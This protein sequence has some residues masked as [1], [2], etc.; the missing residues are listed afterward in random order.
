MIIAIV[1]Q[2]TG[3]AWARDAEGNL[4]PLAEG[5]RLTEGEVVITETG[6]RVNLVQPDGTRLAQLGGEVEV[7]ISEAINEQG[8]ADDEVIEDAEVARVLALLEEGE[9]DL[10]EALEAPAAGSAG[11]AG[12]EGGHD[13]VRLLRIVE[14]VSPLSFEYGYQREVYDVQEQDGG[15]AADED[16]SVTLTGLDG[17]AGAAGSA[18]IGFS[19]A[20]QTVSEAGLPGGSGSGTAATSASGSFGVSAPDGLS[21]I[22]VGG[23]GPISLDRLNGLSGN[24]LTIETPLGSLTLTS[25]SG[26]DTGGSVAYTYDLTDNVDN[27]SVDGATDD[28]V[29]DSIEISAV[30]SDG[31]TTSGTLDIAILDDAPEAVDDAT[32]TGEDTAVTYN[33][34][35]NTDGTSD[36]QG[37]DGASVTA[38]SLRNLSQGSVSFD[39]NTGEVTFTPADGFEGDAV[40]DYTIT[41]AD[42]DTSDAVFTVTVAADSTPTVSVPDESPDAEGGQ[43]SVSEAGLPGGSAA[44]DGSQ[45]TGGSLPITTGGDSLASLVINGQNVTGGGTVE[46]DYGT[47]SVSVSD[48]EYSWSYTLDGSTQDHTSQGT[49]SDD[50]A[51]Q[52]AIVVTDSDGD[53]ASTSLTIDVND[54]VPVAV[55]DA[56]N[57]GED[58]PVT[59]NV[60]ANDTQGV[61][62]AS[63]SDATLRN[64]SQGSVSFDSDTGEVTFT[65]AAGFEGDAVIDYTIRDADG[66]TSDAVFT[67]TVAADS[68]PTVSVPDDS[69]DAE[70]GQFSVSEAGLAGGSAAGDGSQTTGGSLPITTG[71]DSLASLVINGQNVTGGGTVEGDYGTLS[72]S[73]SDGEYSWSYTLDGSTQDHTSQGT[74]SDDLADQFSIVVTDSDGDEASTSLTIDVNDDVPV[75]VDDAANTGE[76]TPVTYNVL[77]NDTQGVDGASVSDATLRDPSQGSVSF[78]SDTGEVTF[79]PAAGFE[80]DAVIDYT[81]TDADGDTSD[82]VFT[83]TVAA[84]STPTVSVPDESPESEGGQ[85]SVSEAGLPGGSAA[86]DG[87]QSTGG[88]LP[89]TTGGDSLA[90][91]VIN[92]QNVTGGGTVEGDYGTLSVSVSNGEYSWSYT[93]DGSTQ[94]HTSQGTGSDDLADMFAIVVT[95]SDGDTASTSLTIDVND[96]VPKARDDRNTIAEETASV[97]GN[98]LGNDTTGADTT[99]ADP[100]SVA[101]DAPTGA[102]QYGTLTLNSDGSYTYQLDNDDPRVQ[103]LSGKETLTETFAYTLTDAD[104]D[105]S[106]ATLTITVTGTDDGVSLSG[107]A[108]EGSDVSVSEANLAGGSDADSSALTQP[109]NFTFASVDGVASVQVGNQSL[110]LA[111]LQ[112]LSADSPVVVDTEYGSLSLTGFTPSDSANPAAGG[113][114]SYSYTLDTRVDNDSQAD[115]TDAG[116]TETVA[117]VVTDDDGSA[118]N[119]SLSIAI[120]DDSPSASNDSDTIA[121]ET[122][123]VSGNVLSN[124]T[125]GADTTD[126]DPASV[127]LGAPTGAGQYGTLTLNSDGSYTYQLDNDDPRVQ[128]LSGKETLTE[129]FAYTLTDAD[130]D[131]SPATLTITVT[132]TDDGVSLSGLASE[133]SDVAVSEANLAGGSDADS[134][135][136]TQPGN[137][138]FA[139]V[140]GVASVQVGNQ[141]LSLAQL[142]GLTADSPVVVDTEYGS[143]SLTGF[144]PSDSANPA[145]GGTVSY[146]Y[147]LDTRV[148]NDSQADA[149]DAG[150]TETVALVVT[151]DD[152]SA[153]NGSL[154]IAIA[155]DSPSASNDSDTIAEETASVSGNVLSNDTTGADTTDADPASVALDAPTGAGHYGTLTLNS[156]GSYTY[157][158]DNDDPRVQALSGEEQLTETFAYTLTDADGDTSPATLTIT[159]TG[160]DDG[161]S[162]SGL[163]SEGSDVS[164][165]EANLEEGSAADAAALTQPGN[166]TFASVDGVASVQV[167]NQTLSLAQLQG[168]TADSPVV[169]DTEYGSLSLTGFTPSDSANPAAGGTVSYSYTLD[170]RVDNDS[171]ADATDAGFTETVA[172][173]VTDDDGS[174][175]NGSLS[176]AIADDSPSASNDSDTIAEETA[177]VSGNVLSNDTTGADTTDADPASV[178]LDAPTGA[179]HYG[180]LTL[181]SDGSYT[182]QL[183]NDDPRVQALSGEEQLTETFAYTLT[184]ADGDT[185]PATLTITVTGTDDGVSLSGLASEGSDASVSEANLEEGSAADAAALTQP[186]NFTFAS[187]DGVASVQVGNQSLT[188]AQLQGLSADSPVVVDTEY[189]S[190]SLTGFTPAD[191]ANPAAG[192]TVSYSYTL[193]TRVDNDSQ[194]DATDAGF[195][196]TVALVVTDDDGSAANGSLSIAIA[197]DSPS[198]SNDS[199]TIAEETASVSGNV[200]GNDTTGADTTDADPASVALDAPTGAGHYGTLTL[201][202]DGSYTYQLD[203]D[204][205]RVQALS[206]K[207]TLTETFAYT[208]TDA[209]GDTSPATLTIT[210][211]G[212]DDGVSLSG[213]ASEGSDVSVSEANLAGGSDADSSAL[214][215]P[216]S[217][218]FTSADGV[219]SVQVGNQSLTLAQLQGLSADS[220]VVVDTEYGS[221][222]LTGFTPADSANP[223]AGGTVSYSYTLDTRVDNDSQADATDAGFTETVALVVTDDDGSAANG[224]LS[225]AIADDSP[226]ASNDSDTIAEET[227]SVSGNVL[228]NDTTGAD[229][230]DADSASV[231]LDAPTGAGHYGTLTLNSDGSYTYQLDNDDPRVQALSGKETLTETFA[232]TLTDADGD[233]SPAT[234]T[235]TVTG[236]DDGVSLSGLASEGSDVSVSE[237]NLEEG[238]AADAA[239]L[240]QPGNFT[241]AS[242][243]GVASVQVG[244]QS[245]TLAQ[246]QGLTADS[247][248]VVDTEYGSLSLTGFTPADSANPAAGGTVS[249]SYSLDTRV[250]NDSQADATDAGFTETVGLVVTDD[251]GSAANGSLS[252]AIA[253]DSPSASNDSDTITEETAT[254]TGNVL[255]NDTTG[256]DTTDADPASVALDAPTGAGQYG[257]LT[258]NSDGSYTYQLDN[259]DP[260]VQA[261]SGKE[262]LTETFA[263]TLTDADGDTS[264]ATLTITV[265]GTDDGVSLSGLASEG[266][267]VSVSEANLEEGSAADAAALTQPGNFTFASVDGVASVQVGNQSLTLAQLQGLSADSPVVVDTEY[268]S[269]SLTGFTPSDSANPAAGGTVSYSYTLDTRVD[270]DSQ[271]DATDAGFTETVDLVVTDDDG[272][273]ANGSL[274][275]AIADDAPEA[276]AD[277]NSITEETATVGGN[278]IGGTDSGASAGDAADTLGA[279]TTTVTAVSSNNA[280]GNSASTVD[281]NLVIEG[282][283]G[284]L[285]IASDGSYSYALDNTNPAVQGLDG[286][287]NATEVFTY[288]LTD[289]DNDVSS[290]TLTLTIQGQ[291]DDAPTVTVEDSDADVSGADNSVTEASGETVTGSFTVGGS[292]GLASVT[293]AGVELVGADFTTPV[294]IPN[295]AGQG[296]LSITGFD[297]DSGTFSY[298]YTETG[299]A[300]SHNAADDNIVD[301]F[302]IVVTD[303]EGDIASNSLDIQILDTAPDADDDSTT[304]GEDQSV[305]YNVLAN[306]TQGADGASVTDATLR[307]PSQG[308][309]SFDSDTGE[310]TFTP[311]AGFE[312]DAVIDYTIRDADGDTSDAVFT[313]T[314]AAD[315]TPTVSVPDDSPDAEGGQFSVSEAGLP[316]GSAAGDDSQSTNGSL[317]ITTGGDSLASLVINGQNVTGGGT[318]EGD[319]GTLSVS[320]SDG[321]Y[322]WSYTLDG[323]TQDHTSQGTGSDDLADLFAIV[324]TDS[325]GDTASTSLT[326]DV[327]DDVPVAVDDATTTGEDTAVT[328][329]VL[330]NADGTSDTQGADGASV[331]DATLRD[332]SQGSVSFDSDTGEVTFTPAAGFEGDAVIDY[333]IRDADGDTSDAVFTVTVAADST[334]TVSVPDDSPDAEGGQFSVSEAGLPGGSAAGDDSQSTN[335][336]LPITTG[337]DSLAS[338][339]I[340]GQNV[341]G[342]GTVEGD[343][344]TLSVSVSV[345]LTAST[346]GATP[347][348]GTSTQDHTSQGTGSDAL[349]DQF[350]IVVT[351]SDGDTASIRLRPA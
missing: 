62:G 197:D 190:L 277:T 281:G 191:S 331:T 75:A 120:A 303:H 80:G 157:Q 119:G 310:V 241:F 315:S 329:N 96:D 112:G 351:D 28:G 323:S 51:D 2:V 198:A 239:A 292:A 159:V 262:T 94:D 264:P 217:F 226:S 139:S 269:L 4:R 234:L 137:F 326:I 250:D 263:Y 249:Y 43:F 61:D 151:D 153:A 295:D 14:E 306:D 3:Q 204:D 195:T 91:L 215:Q 189:G 13:F 26:D 167:G 97:S 246:L 44:G 122:A 124:D 20:E 238:S 115:A 179:G 168:L 22:T 259:D 335:G 247:P 210:V 158:L 56:A 216:G 240:T 46:G 27:D 301:S 108:S 132:G 74:G 227:A 63:V 12:A 135:A 260:R 214:T 37:A 317:P 148:D 252:I 332:P 150:F 256:A 72:V 155:D 32:T 188:L 161:V 38:A 50:L 242:V 206:G 258:L 218:T 147:T 309:V 320:V 348:D 255:S 118:A 86:G 41:D 66:D 35:V 221:L 300:A 337:G 29:V 6:A 350:A 311:A 82:A 278:V 92:G 223:A 273:A 212:T 138:T 47:L 347:L 134:S 129:T 68:T 312:G 156:D 52:F 181:N 89:I 109:G 113:T 346:A 272:S 321:E 174:A 193:D 267:D 165:S 98:V 163:A 178:A 67:V 324:V 207:E 336:S 275:I 164:V 48:G 40:I 131:T 220:P 236:T 230:T 127:A 85:F 254:V 36:V 209:D 290:T 308:S 10:L 7:A 60:L 243:D 268:G 343:Y 105:T 33:V 225:I 233:T 128:A 154:S 231:A 338:L 130:G 186:G 293:I 101:L 1:V 103:A 334:P 114:V 104:G 253:D 304:T 145:A 270:N 245:L 30:D 125:T 228:G 341:T 232:Y 285:T 213:L 81:I 289:S 205:P 126:A 328:Y 182:Y 251:D 185:S 283:Y 194:A 345:S 116:F 196:E 349:A 160:T 222:S 25:Y 9:G 229:T 146:S 100:A 202:S 340:N 302:A 297:A 83:V 11:G 79:T 299:G 117:L 107:L 203:N 298:S 54:D 8:S 276:V 169:V 141:T 287:E 342:G 31:S 143:L 265:T 21:F 121:E 93:L 172:L 142:Q 314:V 318:V 162:L 200:L 282:Q 106:P 244:N 296:S 291:E 224:S 140:D 184:D 183:D 19:S 319:Y 344:G 65:P 166:F 237:A 111:Q 76:D 307:N 248:V 69:P 144:T 280:S 88:S 123:S 266:S 339:V 175:A 102:G 201:N 305:A 192:G 199:D 77:A 90:S 330:V 16:E 171:Q 24:P 284:T 57:T 58:T 152:G 55:D 279:D 316:G 133:G 49:G 313:V 70:G 110:T 17:P 99:D 23:S 34:L 257:T 73:V 42:G 211:T 180:T 286:D 87:S 64:P 274:S 53:E 333:T 149:T 177:S 294:T 271:A 18:D 136:L 322:S 235:I 288:T 39:S 71:G 261:L 95:D 59:Y 84:D 219:A 45:S 15:T 187:V 173:V 327:N 170:T 78:D 325:D 176:I 208:L 5:D